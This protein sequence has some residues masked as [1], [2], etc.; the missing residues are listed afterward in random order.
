MATI[1]R[2]G[3]RLSRPWAVSFAANSNDPSWFPGLVISH[4]LCAGKKISL[5]DTGIFVASR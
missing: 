5:M 2:E 4:A 3:L 1:F